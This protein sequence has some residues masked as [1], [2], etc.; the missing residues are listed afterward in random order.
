MIFVVWRVTGDDEPSSPPATKTRVPS[1]TEGIQRSAR[2]T[3]LTA[4]TPSKPSAS[5]GALRPLRTK[6]PEPPPPKEVILQ[7]SGNRVALRGGPGTNHPVLDR[8]D[9]GRPVILLEQGKKWSRVRDRL[10]RREGWVANFLLAPAA[11]ELPP[12]STA[13]KKQQPARI[14][15]KPHLSDAEVTKRIIARSLASYPG[16]CPCP[17]NTDRGGRRCGKRSAY[18]RPGGYAPVCYPSDVTR[19]MILS[20]RGG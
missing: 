5:E 16:S 17:Y 20:Y 7:I 9:K 11:R 4:P 15:P 14:A 8:Y 10:T 12:Q 18:S 3:P 2:Q 13:P 19:Q 6:P 1:A